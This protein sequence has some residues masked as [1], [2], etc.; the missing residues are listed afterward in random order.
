VVLKHPEGTMLAGSEERPDNVDPGLDFAV[1]ADVKQIQIAVHDLHRAGGPRHRYR[2]RIAPPGQPDFRL[3][4]AANRL[5]IPENGTVQTEL[6]L[7]RA[8]YNGAIQLKVEGD[9]AIAIA[10]KQVPAD[11]ASRRV[12]V[13]LSRTGKSATGAL[14]RLRIVGESEGLAPPLRRTATLSKGVEAQIPGFADTLPMGITAPVNVKLDVKELPPTLLKGL[15][16]RIKLAA[17]AEGDAASQTI[18]L[19][20]V[21]T[22]Q[23]RRVDRNNPNSGKKPRV[24]IPPGQTL[25]AGA[26]EGQLPLVV[27]TDVEEP[28]IDFVLRAEVVPHAY[29][30][31]VLATIYSS[32]FRLPVRNAVAINFDTT[33]F[34]LASGAE[35][36]VKGKIVRT[37]PFAGAVD[38]AL[39]GLPEGYKAAPVNIPAGKDEFEFV[40]TSP[41]EKEA[42]TL[43]NLNV[44]AATAGKPLANQGLELKFAP[45]AA[46][47]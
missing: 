2:V 47:K 45:A 9:D 15:D 11:G 33:T 24:D 7:D 43:S 40:V 32:P 42:K 22:E 41:A 39:A 1:P 26:A 19:S 8:G 17:A 4:V 14:D 16:S 6:Q 13:T 23:E 20:L 25:P 21:S 18:R 10:P 44:A 38:L 35:G 31:K 37:A 30:Q 46:K 27:P 34:N 29:S 5:N 3:S 12:F 36:R 28:A